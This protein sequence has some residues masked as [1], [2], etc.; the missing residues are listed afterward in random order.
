MLVLVEVVVEV[1]VSYGQI[2]TSD[3][4]VAVTVVSVRV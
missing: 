1:L 4:T 3:V 2:K